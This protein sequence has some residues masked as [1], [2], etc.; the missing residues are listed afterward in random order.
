MNLEEILTRKPPTNVNWQLAAEF[1]D[2]RED[3][4]VVDDYAYAERFLAR[5]RDHWD[6][7]TLDENDDESVE[8][9]LPVATERHVV[10]WSELIDHLVEPL[11]W[12]M[13]DSSPV[14]VVLTRLREP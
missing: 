14:E 1:P 13:L 10:L 9:Y 7:N 11:N 2:P 6:L 4:V 5:I 8:D 3:G 12:I